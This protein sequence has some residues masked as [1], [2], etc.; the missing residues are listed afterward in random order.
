MSGIAVFC[1]LSFY[2][3]LVAAQSPLQPFSATFVRVVNNTTFTGQ[4]YAA[5]NSYRLQTNG[6]QNEKESIAILLLN[7]NAVHLLQTDTKTEIEMPYVDDLGISGEEFIGYLGAAEINRELI[8]SSKFGQYNCDKFRVQVEYKGHKYTQIEYAAKDLK[9]FVVRRAGENGE[10][11]TEYSNVKLTVQ[12]PSLFE[13]PS[14]YKVI[15]FSRDWRP[16]S[17]KIAAMTPTSKVIAMARAAGLE[18]TGDAPELLPPGAPSNP[19]FYSLGVVDP[20]TRDEVLHIST[21]VDYVPQETLRPARVP[22]PVPGEPKITSVRRR[23]VGDKYL[24]EVSFIL[25]DVHD[26]EFDT[27]KVYGLRMVGNERSNDKEY[28]TIK[29]HWQ[30]KDKVEFSV[31][32]PKEYTDAAQGWNIT[33]C[34]GTDAVCYPST[35]ILKLIVQ[36]K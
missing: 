12:N 23:D 4:I 13:V 16:I 29:G 33:F 6:S 30:P 17:N 35:N 5:P 34:V 8:G 22:N 31:E 7:Q 26:T 15:E 14:D 36:N 25:A 3:L 10:W 2:I 21:N 11:S 27:I 24:L 28:P 20:K 9:G 1:S 18:V 19:T 32:V